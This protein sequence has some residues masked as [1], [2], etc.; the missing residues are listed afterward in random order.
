[1]K[2][3]NAGN[4][5]KHRFVKNFHHPRENVRR[6]KRN[7]GQWMKNI[8]K[9]MRNSGQSYS[10][11]K[12]TTLADGTKDRTLVTRKAK[13]MRPPCDVEKCRLI[14]ANKISDEQRQTL[15]REY[16]A[17]ADLQQQRMFIVSCIDRINPKYRYPTQ[18]QKS[19]GLNNAFYFTFSSGEKICV[20]KYF[21]MAT[22]GINSQVIQTVLK[23]KSSSVAGVIQP[24]KRG[25]HNNHQ[26]LSDTI[27][28]EVRN[29]IRSIPRME[30]RNDFPCQSESKMEYIEGGKTVR[31]LHRDY[32]ELCEEVKKPHVNYLMYYK[33]FKEEFN[34]SFFVPK[35]DACGYC[36]GFRNCT[37]E[38]K[39]TCWKTITNTY[40]RKI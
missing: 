1:M 31:D 3:N 22:L 16:W 27:K 11:I 23:K 34:I 9:T 13:T 29:H 25:K 20:C 19:R 17:M 5:K 7:P 37:E 21:F 12:T 30:S 14:C 4:K 15:F 10:S 38:E 2:Q 39:Q 40:K 33:I 26:A 32:V 24:E 6:V 18:Q 28:D 8:A 36:E 35:K